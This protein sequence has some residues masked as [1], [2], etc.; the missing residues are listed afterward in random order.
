MNSDKIALNLYHVLLEQED[1]TR[2]DT[3]LRQAEW[4]AKELKKAEL[5][6]KIERI[7]TDFDIVTKYCTCGYSGIYDIMQKDLIL[8]QSELDKMDGK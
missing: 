8:A 7:N 5:K 3:C 1:A 4:V 2:L 6:A